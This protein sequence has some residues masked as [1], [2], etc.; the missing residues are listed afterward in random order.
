MIYLMILAL[1]GIGYCAVVMTKLVK[2]V[3]ECIARME[4]RRW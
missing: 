2:L 1:A 3:K 4:G